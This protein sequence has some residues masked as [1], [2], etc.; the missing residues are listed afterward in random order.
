MGEGE[1]A[2]GE[3][4]RTGGGQT[5]SQKGGFCGS[6]SSSYQILTPFLDPIPWHGSM[7]ACTIDLSRT[8]PPLQ[9]GGLPRG[10]LGTL[11]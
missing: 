10:V 2:R 1:M 7:Q 5:G 8:P 11:H 6:G 4:D 9:C 3:R